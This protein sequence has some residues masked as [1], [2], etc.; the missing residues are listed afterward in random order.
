MKNLVLLIVIIIQSS[1]TAYSKI[2]NYKIN[3]YKTDQGL[4]QNNV[5]CIF[6]D[7]RGFIWIGTHYGLNR[8]DG[9]S[10][11]TYHKNNSTISDGYINAITE[12]NNGNLWIATRNGI[13][14]FD[15]QHETFKQFKYNPKN[16]E[17]SI[18][19]NYI[20]TILF[21]S[22]N[23]LWIGSEEGGLE[24]LTLNDS[25]TN[26]THIQ[27]FP[28]D[29][30]NA[31]GISS[32]NVQTIL[33][34]SDGFLYI[35]GI[36]GLDRLNINTG[37]VYKFQDQQN[38][39]SFETTF[40]HTLYEDSKKNIWIGTEYGLFKID[41]SREQIVRYQVD[42]SNE[43]DESK[44]L[45][46]GLITS[47]G[48]DNF[49]NILIG[50]L[51][52]LEIYDPHTNNFTI[53]PVNEEKNRSL[54]NEFIND[55]LCDTYGNVWIGTANG[56]INK[57]NVNQKSFNYLN[58]YQE[59]SNDD[60]KN[61]IINSIYIDENYL[62]IGTAGRGI[63]Y[64]KLNEKNIHQF[65]YSQAKSSISGD[66]ITSIQP[67][68]NKNE[69]WFGTWGQGISKGKLQANGS[70]FFKTYIYKPIT[71]N[72]EPFIYVS[73]MTYDNYGTLWVGTSEGLYYYNPKT[74]SFVKLNSPLNYGKEIKNIGTLQCDSNNNLWIGTTTGLNRIKTK[75]ISETE[76]IFQPDSVFTYITNDVEKKSIAGN[77][78][79]DIYEDSEGN[80]WFA[81]YGEGID[82]LLTLENNGKEATFAHINTSNGLTNPV[83]YGMIEDQH[84][85]LWISTEKGLTKYNY[86]NGNHTTYY[87]NDGLRNDQFYWSAY[88]KHNDEIYFGSTKGLL[89]F[90]PDSIR[91]N[92]NTPSTVITNF[93][94]FNQDLKVSENGILQKTISEID[95]ITLKHKQNIISFEFSALSYYSP[96]DNK[97]QYKLEGFDED[98]VNTS[99]NRRFA[100]YTNLDP[101][102]YTFQVKASNNDGIWNSTPNSIKLIIK[103]PWWNTI[104]FYIILGL[105]LIFIIWLY[106]FI[107]NKNLRKAKIKLEKLVHERTNALKA[108]T[109]DLQQKTKALDDSN[110]E[111]LKI[112]ETKN[113]LFTVIAHDLKSPF[114]V[115]LGMTDILKSDFTEFEEKD[116]KDMLEAVYESSNNL[117][118]L[119]DN[120]LQWVKS[121]R[122]DIRAKIENINIQNLINK[123]IKLFENQA[124]IKSV[125]LK[126]EINSTGKILADKNMIDVVIRN[127]VSNAIKF[128]SNGTITILTEDHNHNSAKISIIDTGVGMNSEQLRALFNVKETKSTVGTGGEKGT[129]L[130]LLV[131]K[132]FVEK[133]GGELTV[134]SELNKGTTFSFTLPMDL[135]SN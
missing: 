4:S 36:Y 31:K 20:N 122:V 118:E 54:N 77:F 47:I 35:G 127:L 110:K 44:K 95:Q 75:S 108:K 6:R 67:H 45:H 70:M 124:K 121:Q 84:H 58:G 133:N 43:N 9:Y 97:Y 51:G 24:R 78:I 37:E 128:T 92:T 63:N 33:K 11:I 89:Y 8:F 64:K 7:S 19:N 91:G 119:L 13:N 117:Y 50:T 38:S 21:D 30:N 60:I 114:N 66:Y 83:I 39:L 123:T 113:K 98:W 86:K 82:K 87:E 55:V 42:S 2:D 99:Y 80:I 32:N 16:P 25:L 29:F 73:S 69:M 101:G 12:D 130:G 109:F 106:S 27:K 1:F 116:L 135:Y 28:V 26:I 96:E 14:L 5:E 53:F 71:S 65:V 132:E 74:D 107:H 131:C 49:G 17:K 57:Y 120:L 46:H 129:G 40:I 85:N 23:T 22:T 48:E 81:I 104:L 102:E 72:G 103:P 62:W 52:G 115:I 76:Y 61:A 100:T 88:A 111:L 90:N 125:I 126:S 94:L 3:Y 112:N 15:F 56:G 134:S 59:Y 41:N 18:T 79:T 105:L 93:K 10:F 34:S 68:T